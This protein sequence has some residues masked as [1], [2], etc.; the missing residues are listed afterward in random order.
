M[1]KYDLIVD[2]GTA[3]KRKSF[4]DEFNRSTT[5]HGESYDIEERN[6]VFNLKLKPGAPAS[7]TIPCVYM[8][9]CDWQ[10]LYKEPPQASCAQSSGGQL[11]VYQSPQG[12]LWIDGSWQI[13]YGRFQKN[14]RNA[15]VEAAEQAYP[16]AKVHSGPQHVQ[17]WILVG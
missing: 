13:A 6:G 7:G 5:L 8:D 16:T 2:V 15:R 4:L 14:D 11:G 10:T 17:G 1:G 3:A 9:I 12:E